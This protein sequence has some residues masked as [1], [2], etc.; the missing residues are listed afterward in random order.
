MAF[1]VI[2]KYSI[3]QFIP[4]PFHDNTKKP[5][6]FVIIRNQLTIHHEFIKTLSLHT[7]PNIPLYSNIHTRSISCN[8]AMHEATHTEIVLF[9]TRSFKYFAEIHNALRSRNCPLADA[10]PS[11]GTLVRDKITFDLFPIVLAPN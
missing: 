6:Y 7:S 4:Y 10:A 2:N 11:R 9:I 8:T 5:L 1:H 3:A